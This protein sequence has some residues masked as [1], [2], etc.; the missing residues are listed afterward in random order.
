M[1]GMLS[2]DD[3]CKPIIARAQMNHETYKMLYTQCIEHIQRKHDTGCTIT[4]FYVPDFVLGRPCFTHSHAVRYISEKLRRGKFEVQI[5]GPVIHIDWE[6]RIKE[7]CKR[8]KHAKMKDK[9]QKRGQTHENRQDNK[10]IKEITVKHKKDQLE[11]LSV[12]LER[13]LKKST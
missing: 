4:L 10:Y 5:D 3:L 8:A 13:L 9:P 12:R 6:A 1:V 7:A 11:P 2:V